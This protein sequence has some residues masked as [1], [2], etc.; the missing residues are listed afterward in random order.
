MPKGRPNTMNNGGILLD[1][2]G[3][4]ENFITPLRES[5]LDPIAKIL[6]PDWV[7]EKLDSHK[8]FTVN[9]KE[10]QDLDLGFH[11][12]NAEVTLNVCIG[13]DFDDGSLYF[14]SMRQECN[15]SDKTVEVKHKVGEGVLHRGQH[16][17]GA[18]P[19][20]YGERTNLII[21]MRS[22]S[23]RNQLCPMCDNKP[24]LAPAIGLGDGFTRHDTPTVQVCS[25]H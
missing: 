19:I 5:Y 17:H 1:E 14:G 21:W 22:S 13:K 25:L 10:D 12:D 4:N 11:Y 16:K 9:Y 23:I 18:M 20:S 6:F 24:T 3:F 15:R 8:S 7:D 2:L